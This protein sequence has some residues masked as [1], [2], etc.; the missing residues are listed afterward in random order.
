MTKSL[1]AFAISLAFTSTGWTQ[2]NY[3]PSEDQF[4]LEMGSLGF[5]IQS[6]TFSGLYAYTATAEKL[7]TSATCYVA[8]EKVARFRAMVQPFA[9]VVGDLT[10]APPELQSALVEGK[11][12]VLLLW[13]NFMIL[14]TTCFLDD[15]SPEKVKS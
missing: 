13:T 3:P 10:D 2:Q 11:R 6:L 15:V 14:E 7:N 5:D 12:K 1:I 9:Y 8:G 4:R